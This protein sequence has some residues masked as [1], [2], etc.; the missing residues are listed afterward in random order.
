MDM[1][2]YG[3]LP[4][5]QNGC[6]D[7]GILV[8]PKTGEVFV[9]AVW[10]LGR[11]GTHQWSEGGSEPGFEIGKTAQFLMV[12]SKDDGKTWS[13]PENLTR[14]L[15]KEEWILFAPSPQQG[16]ALA[17]GTLIMPGQGRDENCL[18][19]TSP[20]PRDLWISRMP[21]SA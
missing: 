10:T 2:E 9:T 5:E 20:S 12:R 3:G 1:G 19:Y 4:Q 13:K 14:K 21:S 8:D 11:P 6:S 18:L 15:K 17:D 7:P 16:I